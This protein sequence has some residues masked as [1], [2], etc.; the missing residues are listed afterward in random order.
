MFFLR[1]LFKVLSNETVNVGLHFYAPFHPTAIFISYTEFYGMFNIFFY[2][3][4]A[5]LQYLKLAHTKYIEIIL[6]FFQ[7]D[8]T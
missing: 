5:K 3:N 7:K 1:Q 4:T 8:T 2:Y 6:G